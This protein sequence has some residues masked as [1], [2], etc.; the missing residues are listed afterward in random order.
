MHQRPR[1]RIPRS[2]VRTAALALIALSGTGAVASAATAP[3]TSWVR[4]STATGSSN[5]SANGVSALP[6]GT[7]V[8]SG[9]FRGSSVDFGDG[10][11]RSSAESGDT[12]SAFTEGL[13]AS[14]SVRW[15]RASTATGSSYTQASRISALPDGTAV[16]TGAFQGIAVDFGDGT[17][18]TSAGDGDGFSAF[19]E[20]LSAD[21]SVRWVRTSTAPGTS[22]TSA[23]G[24]SALPD[25][26]AVVSGYFQGS[27]VDF[28]D[29][30]PRTSA[31]GGDDASAFTEGLSADGS[32][33]WVR[34]ST[35]TGSSYTSASGVSGLPDGTAVVSGAFLG[36]SVDFGDGTPS[37]SA[38]SGSDLSAFTQKFLAVPSAPTA[39]VATAGERS[40]SVSI[41]PLSGGSVTS[42]T[43]TASTGGGTCTITAPA[44]NCT[45]S[46]LA[47]GT[48]YTFTATATNATGTS[49]PSAASNAVV[50]TAP[51]SPSTPP[52]P[53]GGTTS[54]PSTQGQSSTPAVL[55]TAPPSQ[56]GGAVVTTGVVPDGATRV[57]QTASGGRS[58][59]AQMAFG[60]HATARVTNTCKITTTGST[61]TYTCKARL[62]AG[63][64]TL[65]TQAKAG[66]RVIA[67][68]VRRVTVKASTRTAVTG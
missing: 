37:A 54:Q 1:T 27:Q 31:N 62:G 51:S 40:A 34:V 20:G 5:T 60:A 64:W 36:S 21:G 39:P 17:P 24:V 44:T 4:T 55:R 28:G 2:H 46:G 9:Y 61:R 48:S 35:A 6:D 65:T 30:T 38:G 58:Q 59:M 49:D 53:A 16:V 12:Y 68:S 29:G 18:R 32:V 33:R 66:A 45:I 50:P 52:T 47:G 57:I 41:S 26:T 19:T 67:Q 11:Q 22:N 15:V 23:S 42:Y 56:Q 63:T 43:V 10:I 25:G 14:G 8:V 7:A 13:S 3:T